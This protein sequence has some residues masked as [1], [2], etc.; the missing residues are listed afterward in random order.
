MDNE[1][2]LI[3]R[4][5]KG[6]QRAF[7]DLIR[8]YQRLV[9]HIVYRMVRNE[10]DREE[11]C[12]ITFI[13]VHK[14]LHR[15]DYRSKLSTWIGKIAY[16][17][18]LDFLKKRKVPFIDDYETYEEGAPAES[19]NRTSSLWDESRQPDSLMEGSDI[20]ERM[21]AEMQ[22]IPEHY[23]AILTLYHM[24]QLSYAEIGEITNLPEGTVK[25][26]LFR[27]RR[28]LKQRLLSNYSQEEIMS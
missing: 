6:D 9:G 7:A 4:I 2:A 21:F 8:Q 16:N 19:E 23:R 20:H 26:Y 14:S 25:S 12:Q 10:A 13:K 27:A 3:E 1:K 5:R 17:S 22:Q 18:T 15:F 24:D 11:L 28:I